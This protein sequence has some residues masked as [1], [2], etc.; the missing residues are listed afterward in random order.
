VRAAQAAREW[1]SHIERE[2]TECLLRGAPC[3]VCLTGHLF[4]FIDGAVE[5]D[6]CCRLAHK[7]C[8][9]RTGNQCDCQ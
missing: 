3:H 2:C 1:L 4:W 9:A 5:C 8:L 6:R 7:T